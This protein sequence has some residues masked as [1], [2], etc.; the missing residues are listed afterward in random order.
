MIQSFAHNFR[1]AIVLAGAAV[2]LG[3]VLALCSCSE[4]DADMTTALELE[5][6]DQVEPEQLEHVLVAPLHPRARAEASRFDPY[7]DWQSWC[8]SPA[9]PCNDHDDC[10]PDRTGRARKCVRPYWSEKDKV[11]AIPFPRRSE[12]ERTREE[13]ELIVDAQCGRGC[14]KGELVRF[15]A[16]VA[17]RESS[18]RPW[19]HHRLNPD[20]VASR[21]SWA[22]ARDRYKGN[23]HYPWR[24]RW[25]GWGMLGQQSATFTG[26]WD[27]DAPPEVLCRPTVA[28]ATYLGC[29]RRA[30][31]KQRSLGI[32]TTW[33]TLHTACS[34][35]QVVPKGPDPRFRGRAARAGW[36]GTEVV[37]DVRQLGL[38]LGPS[39]AARNLHLMAIEA[40]LRKETSGS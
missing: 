16:L 29:S 12:R 13:L 5:V 14:D 9:D 38:P 22:R 26:L 24:A 20:V 35:G 19:K 21:T 8:E 27:R 31:V 37:H 36:D 39:P 2:V 7:A 40:S 33:E 3:V 17:G 25:Q 32:T 10:K 6:L 34:L 28:V 4:A 23:V 1:W 18:Y 30:F 15:V 11:C